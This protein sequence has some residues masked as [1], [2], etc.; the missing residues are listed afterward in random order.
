VI[1]RGRTAR[2]DRPPAVRRQWEDVVVDSR[3]LLE[4]LHSLRLPL[5]HYV[6]TGSGPLAVRELRE[7][8]DIDIQVD[9][10]LWAQLESVYGPSEDGRVLSVD[11][12]VDVHRDSA[13][14]P[15]TGAG[16]LSEQVRAADVIEGVAFMSLGHTKASKRAKGRPKD[17]EDIRLVEA[18]ERSQR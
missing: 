6:V 16:D 9:D 5:G 8:N 2:A 10:E 17:L 13:Y 11:A 4:K 12:D 14:E 1:Q 7:A 3:R 15:L 18:W